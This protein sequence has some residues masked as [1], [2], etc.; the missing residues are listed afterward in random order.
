M[1]DTIKIDSGNTKMIAHQGLFGLERGNSVQAFIAAGNRAK[2]YGIETDVHRT[3]DGR[4]VVI[5]DS[6]TL[7]VSGVDM[8]VESSTFE[9]LRS[10]R[11][12]DVDH[13]GLKD[14]DI[15][16][17]TLEEYITICKYYGKKAVLE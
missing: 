11:L 4:Y 8:D 2:Y 17:P 13:R 15:R 6:N 9:Q 1:A 5:H 12:R 3:A 10:V 16:I 14:I 7:G